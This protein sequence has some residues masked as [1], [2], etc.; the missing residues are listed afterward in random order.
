MTETLDTAWAWDEA[1]QWL[2]TDTYPASRINELEIQLAAAYDD[3]D[4]LVVECRMLR[5]QWNPWILRAEGV[6]LGLIVALLVVAV[7]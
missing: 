1:N 4:D 6:V 2:N 5:S 3:I 7:G